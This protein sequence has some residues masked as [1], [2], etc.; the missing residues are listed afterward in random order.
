M[1]QDEFTYVLEEEYPDGEIWKGF[2]I[3]VGFA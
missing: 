2:F 1:L 3:E